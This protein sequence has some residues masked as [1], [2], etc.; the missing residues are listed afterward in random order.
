M[1]SPVRIGVRESGALRYSGAPLGKFMPVRSL[2]IV[3]LVAAAL[4]GCG[5]RGGLEERGVAPAAAT[6]PAPAGT[7]ASPLDPGAPG[8]IQEPAP[9]LA[10]K[11]RFFLDFLL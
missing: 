9:P 8:V 7:G 5:R 1:K 2:I 6:S 11:R 10:P 4:T 3:L